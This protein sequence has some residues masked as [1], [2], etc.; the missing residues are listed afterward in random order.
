MFGSQFS[1]DDLLRKSTLPTR[2]I[3]ISKTLQPVDFQFYTRFKIN[4]TF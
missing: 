4:P 1:E 3:L 2:S